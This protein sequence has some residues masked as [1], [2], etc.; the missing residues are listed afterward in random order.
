MPIQ[1]IAHYIVR[2]QTLINNGKNKIIWTKRWNECLPFVSIS[3]SVLSLEIN[4]VSHR[5]KISVKLILNLSFIWISIYRS[6]LLR[7]C[8]AAHYQLAKRHGIC[9]VQFV[10]NNIH[11]TYISHSTLNK[12]MR[13]HRHVRRLECKNKT[14][15]NAKVDCI[16]S[17][18]QLHLLVVLQRIFNA[19][20]I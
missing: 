15:Q 18:C 17:K 11:H 10:C 7:F 14:R 1:P 12:K 5:I 8:V 4:P 2:S 3:V 19:I 16:D 6:I 13:L 9:N 20:S